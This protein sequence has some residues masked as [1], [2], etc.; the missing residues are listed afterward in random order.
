MST[1]QADHW[2]FL[3]GRPVSP[4]ESSTGV[5]KTPVVLSQSSRSVGV[6]KFDFIIELKHEAPIL[7]TEG[8]G[9]VSADVTQGRMYVTDTIFHC[10]S[11]SG[12]S[13]CHTG[14]Q[15]ARV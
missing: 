2:G 9:H 6:T 4:F 10:E 3:K 15:E 13:Q 11:S 5:P 8:L 7:T 14:H 12:P 1:R